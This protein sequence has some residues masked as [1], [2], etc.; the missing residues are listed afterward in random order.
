M[1]SWIFGGRYKN[2]SVEGNEKPVSDFI[3]YLFHYNDHTIIT[4]N[5]DLMCVMKVDGFSF[6]TAD[7]DDLDAKKATRNN[8]IKGM[9][10]SD[11]STMFHTIRRKHTAYPDGEFDDGFSKNLNNQWKKHHN[12]D[13]TYTNEHYITLIRKAPSKIGALA[14]LGT[15]NQDGNTIKANYNELEEQKERMMNGLS[16]YRPK[17]LSLVKTDTETYSE[18]LEFFSYITNICTSQKILLPR[19]TIDKAVCSNRLFFGSNVIEVVGYNYHKYAGIVSLKEYRPST[20]AGMMDAFLRLPFE[21]VMSQSF[22]ASDRMASIGAM[23]LQQRRLI[24]SE[25]VAISQIQEINEALDAA[26]SGEFSF[27]SHHLSIMCIADNQKDLDSY[28][29]QAIVEFA[30][31]GVSA[32]REGMNMEA[33]FWA[34]LPGNFDFIVRKSTINSLN[35]SAY[36]SLHNYPSGK[37][38]NNHWGDAVTVFNTTS[39][40][41]FFFSFHARDVGHTMIV[42]PTGSGKTVLL[43]F[44]AAQAQKFRPRTFFFD[45]DHGA[46]IFIRAIG[47]KY[48]IIDPGMPCNFNPLQLEDGTD[49]RNFLMEW[50]SALV[51]ING[52]ALTAEDRRKIDIAI[53][54]NFKLP[55]EQRNLTNIAPFFGIETPESIASRLRMWYGEGSKAKVF[56]NES[57]TIDFSSG[58]I[59]GF[60]MGEVLKDKII[61]PPTLLYIFHRISSSLDGTPTM[62]ILDEA[63]ALIDN[64]VFAP[65]IKDWLKVMRKLNAFVV[66]ATQSVEDAADSP[67]S[68]TLVQQT[69]TQIFLPNLKATSVYRSTFMLSEREFELVKTTEPSTRFFLIKQDANGVVARLDLSG[70]EETIPILSGRADTVIILHR[71]IEEAGEDPRQWMPIFLKTLE[72]H[73]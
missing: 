67:I 73:E 32:T 5:S 48:T 21:F 51:T 10:N 65:K 46:E 53:D 24:Q 68:S 40:T 36:A 42:G 50:L 31:I 56:D 25:D 23:Q 17:L 72:N 30:N 12:P 64:P 3:P 57:D 61:L 60:E 44:L 41:P 69:A 13:Y 63:W 37:S 54:G 62:V 43:N 45:K 38:K 4:K 39:G 52:E 59:F 70:M 6:E 49:N 15:G 33:A 1:L 27:G 9:A 34:Q 20:Y 58:R 71:I 16:S 29:S 26:M 55:K 19:N 8:L 35:L 47:G 66:F 22:T 28:V 18:I 7:D 14:N 2:A 11:F